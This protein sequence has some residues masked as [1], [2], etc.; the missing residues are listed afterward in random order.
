MMNRFLYVSLISILTIAGFGMYTHHDIGS[1][2]IAFSDYYFETNFLVAG[3]AFL[4]LLFVFLF[5][6]HGLRSIGRLFGALI[7][8]RQAKKTERANRQLTCG[9]LAYYEEDLSTAEK[10]LRQAIPLTEFPLIARILSAKVAQRLQAYE[11]RDQDLSVA[12]QNHPDAGISLTLLHSEMQLQ[13]NQNEQA[14]AN[15]KQLHHRFPDH[16]VI[17]RKLA[18]ACH[19]LGDWQNLSTLVEALRKKAGLDD[20][21]LLHYEVAIARGNLADAGNTDDLVACWEKLPAHLQQQVAVLESHVGQLQRFGQNALAEQTLRKY[22]EAHWDDKVIERY[23][24]LD[25]HVDNKTLDRIESWLA[26]RPGHPALLL[27]LGKACL[28][29]SLWGKAQNYLTACLAIEPLPEACLK[30]AEL[31]QN[32]MDAPA[33]AAEYYRKGLYLSLK[34]DFSPVLHNRASTTPRLSVVKPAGG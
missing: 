24:R 34:Q 14:L 16:P 23:S 26:D 20:E 33:E 30:L 21:L 3:A 8:N 27:A 6:Y 31:L 19:R 4:C 1:I 25:I 10:S 29:L 9:L 22:L 17:T 28:N 18:D 7:R 12:R 5:I 32:H 15:L 2:S 13:A 11:R